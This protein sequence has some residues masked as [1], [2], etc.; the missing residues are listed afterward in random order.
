MIE[1]LFPG[2]PEN[3]WNS[4]LQRLLSTRKAKGGPGPGKTKV[5]HQ[6]FKVLAGDEEENIFQD[7]RDEVET[8]WRHDF[9]IERMGHSKEAASALTPNPIK[10]LRPPVA[11]CVLVWQVARYA[12][13]AYWPLSAPPEAKTAKK[14]KGAKR[15][16]THTSTSASYK[17][18]RTQLQALLHCVKFLWKHYAKEGGETRLCL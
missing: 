14:S 18:K 8:K 7:L 6:V 9:V 16:K 13:E 12:F 15:R 5:M 11:G 10:E 3:E 2:L 1:K 4:M 17:V